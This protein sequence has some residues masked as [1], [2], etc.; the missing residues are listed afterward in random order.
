[1]LRGWVF[2]GRIGKRYLASKQKL[3]RSGEDN[4]KCVFLWLYVPDAVRVSWERW[5]G[6][7]MKVVGLRWICK[8]CILTNWRTIT[9]FPIEKNRDSLCNFCWKYM[10][11][12]T[13]E[14]FH[15]G[16]FLSILPRSPEVIFRQE[17]TLQLGLA[18]SYPASISWYTM[19][20]SCWIQ[21]CV[22]FG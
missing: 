4:A 1:M 2:T 12:V 21:R 5:D 20:V 13:L 19:I 8:V 14:D 6:L 3:A 11:L 10:Q 22:L 7:F 15:A 16:F 9:S 17:S 18:L